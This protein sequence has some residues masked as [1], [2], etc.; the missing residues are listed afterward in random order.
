MN[1]LR[2]SQTVTWPLAWAYFNLFYRPEINV[3]SFI[4]GLLGVFTGQHGRAHIGAGL[5]R[6]GCDHVIF[7]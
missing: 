7:P 5:V 3:I 2:I 4:Y 1:P 6:S